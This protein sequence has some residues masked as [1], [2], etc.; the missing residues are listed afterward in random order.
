MAAPAPPILPVRQRT[1]HQTFT[2]YQQH[3][4]PGTTVAQLRAI[5]ETKSPAQ[6][7]EWWEAAVAIVDQLDDM[8]PLKQARTQAQND[9]N[10]IPTHAQPD[11]DAY[12]QACATADRL[13]RELQPMYLELARQW[14]L[15]AQLEY[16]QPGFNLQSWTNAQNRA[17][18]ARSR[19][20]STPRVLEAIRQVSNSTDNGLT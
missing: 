12:F 18:I 9:M 3:F 7:K 17:G 20:N 4:Q 19:A 6:K 10:T 13:V 15:L 16:N 1:H 11:L 14:T 2:H 8:H 5:W